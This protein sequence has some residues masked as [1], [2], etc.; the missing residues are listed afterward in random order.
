VQ[1]KKI[2]YVVIW[3]FYV[4]LILGIA[5]AVVLRRSRLAPLFPLLALP[6]AV[7]L[8]VA[9]TFGQQRY[10][11]PMQ[12]TL[13]ILGAVALDALGRQFVRRRSRRGVDEPSSPGEPV[14][15]LSS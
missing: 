4:S 6:A 13:V 1:G 10:R 2:A 9:V 11:A 8:S 15:A 7:L 14:T 12:P 5:G 3:A